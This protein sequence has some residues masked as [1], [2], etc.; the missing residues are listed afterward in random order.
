MDVDFSVDAYILPK[1]FVTAF[2]FDFW[3]N[4]IWAWNIS[5]WV[6]RTPAPAQKVSDWFMHQ[7]MVSTAT[8]RDFTF[9]LIVII[10]F[11]VMF[12]FKYAWTFNWQSWLYLCVNPILFANSE[13]QKEYQFHRTPKQIS[14][15]WELR[16]ICFQIDDFQFELYFIYRISWSDH[17]VSLLP[18]MN[19]QNHNAS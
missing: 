3:F 19:T 4:R 14:R 1:T 12:I 11:H 13:N 15:F 16:P 17:S 7:W 10:G 9:I 5:I 6:C 2:P 18:W 8:A